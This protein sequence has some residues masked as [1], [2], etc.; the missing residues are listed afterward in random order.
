MQFFYGRTMLSMDLIDQ[1]RIF[2]P[3]DSASLSIE[4]SQLVGYRDPTSGIE[5]VAK[6][7]GTETI[8][9][10]QTSKSVA[11]RMLQYA[12]SL[13]QAAYQV[14]SVQP[15]GELVYATDGQGNPVPLGSQAAA[16]A[17]T[18]LRNYTTNIDVVRQLTLFFG[19]G[20]LGQ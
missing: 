18:M 15:N 6:N 10:V 20:P 8:N 19:Y 14:S 9:G 16:D 4:P 11:S 17:A 12:N 13:A 3:G 7:Y 5:Y 2:S 1:L